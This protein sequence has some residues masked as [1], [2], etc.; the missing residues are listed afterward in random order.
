MAYTTVNKS[1]D[2]QN[3]VLY[4]GNGATKAVTGVGFQPD[5]VWIKNRSAALDHQV[6][7]VTRGVTYKISPNTN[8]EQTQQSASFTAFGADG[9]TV[10][11][12]DPTNQLDEAFASWN[13]KAGTTSGIAGSPNTTPTAYSFNATAGF[14]IIKYVGN[15]ANT[16]L[17]HGLGV[18]P[19]MI[20]CKELDNTGSWVTY[21]EGLGNTKAVFLD[22][23]QVPAVDATYWQDTTPT[24]TL[25]SLGSNGNLNQDTVNYIAYCFAE[26]PGY[27]KFGTYTGNNNDDGPFIYTGFKPTFVITK[28]YTTAEG[29]IMQDNKRKYDVLTA[30]T[31]NPKGYPLYVN[32]T[33]VWYANTYAQTDL[34]SNG[35]KLRVSHGQINGTASFIYMAFGQ[36]LVGTNNIPATAR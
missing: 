21:H 19:K 27:S 24:S 15:G 2:Y 8:T 34:L 28:S 7:D 33:N 12:Y 1:S 16:T 3:T 18:A 17:P 9:F 5:L 30:V 26:I 31:G 10:D 36:T 35:F 4:T 29:W 20:I 22:T 11:N 14:S 23:T 32:G 25:F 6:F 13:W